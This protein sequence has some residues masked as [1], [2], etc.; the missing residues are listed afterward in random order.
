MAVRGPG[1]FV[2]VVLA[3]A[4]SLLGVEGVVADELALLARS[5]EDWGDAVAG[6]HAEEVGVEAE[7]VEEPVRSGPD[8]V[9]GPTGADQVLSGGDGTACSKRRPEVAMRRMPGR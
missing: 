8:V 1:W 9:G 5:V 2:P 6:P 3:V 4:L 7:Q